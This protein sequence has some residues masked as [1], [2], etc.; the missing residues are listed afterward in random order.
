M[1]WGVLQNGTR[2]LQ[3]QILRSN[4][5]F[6]ELSYILGAVAKW[7]KSFLTIRCDQLSDNF[8]WCH[9]FHLALDPCLHNTV[10]KILNYYCTVGFGLRS[11][12]LPLTHQNR[13]SQLIPQPPPLSLSKCLSHWVDSKGQITSAWYYHADVIV[14][15]RHDTMYHAD[16]ILVLGPK[17]NTIKNKLEMCQFYIHLHS[18]IF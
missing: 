10:T 9:I 7:K 11:P 13:Y 17:L 2:V 15:R 1:V 8:N 6:I 18:Y 3:T 12:F 5:H 4:F 16:V 14:S